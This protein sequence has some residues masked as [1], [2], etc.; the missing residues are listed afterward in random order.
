MMKD[1]TQFTKRIIIE[2]PVSLIYDCWA[3]G[4][5]FWLANLKAYIEHGITLNARGLRQEETTDLVNS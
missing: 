1:W 3:T 2:K 5:T 4:W